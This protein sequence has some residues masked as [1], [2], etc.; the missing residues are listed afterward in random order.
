M[1]YNRSN[2]A[3]N[4]R[5][6]MH[7]GWAQGTPE[8][9][10]KPAQALDPPAVTSGGKCPEHEIPDLAHAGGVRGG[11]GGAPCSG[12]RHVD[13]LPGRQGLG[14][15]W[16]WVRVG[17]W[18]VSDRQHRRGAEAPEGARPAKG[19]KSP[20]KLGTVSSVRGGHCRARHAKTTAGTSVFVF[21]SMFSTQAS[22]FAGNGLFFRSGEMALHVE[23]T[24]PRKSSAKKRGRAP[25]PLL[26]PR[27]PRAPPRV[28]RAACR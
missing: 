17:S 10:D 7:V 11:P 24:K 16:V 1:C 20:Q 21:K 3:S 13:G 18:R 9:I 28:A 25:K 4:S 6:L 26:P 15:K 8:Q 5:R 19:K 23:K 22:F 14:T 27:A 2:R 12:P